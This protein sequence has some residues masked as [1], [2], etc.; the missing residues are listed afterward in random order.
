MILLTVKPGE[1]VMETLTKLAADAAVRNGAIVSLIGA[2]DACTIS[3]MPAN[4]ATSDIIT[5]YNQPCE[6]TG[7]GDITDGVVHV[8]VSL[9][10]EGDVA[11]AGHLHRA[12][13]QTFFVKA[14]ILELEG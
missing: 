11:I 10:R 5:D 9:G 3:N 1:E 12:T 8:H 4:N 14:Y 7:T 6:L 2:V 13:V